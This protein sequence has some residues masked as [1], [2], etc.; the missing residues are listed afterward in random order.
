M[1]ITPERRY[2][3]DEKATILTTIAWAQQL[4]P[5]RRLTAILA[6]LGLPR[7]TYYRWQPR[8]MSQQ[9][10]D[11]VV[12]PSRTAVPPTPHEI[13]RVVQGAQRHLL[14]GY[15]RL[16]YALMAENKAFLRPWMVHDILDQH[17]LLGRRAPVPEPLVRPAAADHP[18]QRWHTDLSMW[19]F[20]NQWFWMLDILDAYSRYLVHCELL[21]TAKTD[22]VERAVQRAL[23]TLVGRVRLAG[24]PQIVHDGGPQFIGHDWLQFMQAV[25]ATN[26]RT[27]PYHPQSN[28]LD[29]RVHRTFRE[30]MPIEAEAI[31][32]E[33]QAT[34]LEYRRYY[35]DRRPHSALKYL[36]PVDYYRGDPVARFAEREAKLR[37]AAVARTAYWQHERDQAAKSIS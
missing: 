17:Q 23:D 31:L 21:L 11:R 25:G 15:K 4:C 8:G 14:L 2:S 34:M 13:E 36:C 5:D 7:A 24:E 22:A 20:D 27:H 9:L 6:D 26:V 18:D 32:Y 19:W 37:A 1:A 12:V 3:T 30:E 10:A 16:A 33:A 29:E 28:G 35:N